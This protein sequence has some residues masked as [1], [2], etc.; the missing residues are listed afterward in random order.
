MGYIASVPKL[1]SVDLECTDAGGTDYVK[2]PF[3]VMNLDVQHDIGV[4]PIY[5]VGGSWPYY[6][7]QVRFQPRS[8]GGTITL[9]GFF[10][11]LENYEETYDYITN[12]SKINPTSSTPIA[13]LAD[14]DLRINGKQYTR[15]YCVAHSLRSDIL[16]GGNNVVYG[17]I[18]YRFSTVED[19]P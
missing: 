4:V 17:H 1:S 16:A 2:R 15:C 3:Y 7:R 18:T 6:S 19:Y 13:E 5:Y 14:L 11:T 12:S 8:G 9:T 10:K